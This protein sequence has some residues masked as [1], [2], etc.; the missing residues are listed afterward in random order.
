MDKE[1]YQTFLKEALE[2]IQKAHRENYLSIFAGAGVSVDSG[3]PK[4]STLMEKI[5]ESIESNADEDDFLTIEKFYEQYGEEVCYQR[6]KEWIHDNAEPNKLHDKIVNLNIKNLITTNWDNLFEKAMDN[7]GTFF[8]EIKQDNDIRYT[9]GYSR[10]V[11]MHGSLDKNNIVFRKTDYEQYSNKFPLIENYVKAIFS[12]D[13]VLLVGYSLRDSNVQQILSWLKDCSKQKKFSIYLVKTKDEFSLQ[14]FNDCREKYDVA[15]FYLEELYPQKEHSQQLI[16]FFEYIENKSVTNNQQKISP[17]LLEHE[18]DF[19]VEILRTFDNNKI[20]E[21]IEKIQ[22]N[23]EITD[24]QELQKAFLLYHSQQ[25]LESYE[26]LKRLSKESFKHRNHKIWYISEFNRKNFVFYCDNTLRENDKDTEE[27]KIEEYLKDKD[28]NEIDLEENYLKLPI[29]VR[30]NIKP[31]TTLE[32]DLYKNIIEIYHLK[33]SISYDYKVYKNGGIS[34][35]NNIDRL[36]NILSKVENQRIGFCLL[37]DYNEFFKN[38]IESIFI[39]LATAFLTR[40]K[41]IKANQRNI[42][43]QPPEM[44]IDDM[45]MPTNLLSYSIRYFKTEYLQAI[46]EKYYRSDDYFIFQNQESLKTIFTNI[47]SLFNYS[48]AFPTSYSR[49]FN[50]FLIISAWIKVGQNVFNFILENF[51]D[52]LQNNIISWNEYESM[53]YFIKCQCKKLENIDFDKIMDIVCSYMDNIRQNR[54]RGYDFSA[55]KQIFPSILRIL[56]DKK[57][58]L[59]ANKHKIL[60]EHFIQSIPLEG[61]VKIFNDFIIELYP[62]ADKALRKSISSALIEKIQQTPIEEIKAIDK[63]QKFDNPILK[64]M[65]PDLESEMLALEK[66]GLGEDSVLEFCKKCVDKGVLSPQ[67]YEVL[68][69]RLES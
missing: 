4:W 64:T 65:P 1:E 17:I 40:D 5:K 41:A 69:A 60:V 3:M 62:I 38:T 35:N 11:K 19:V 21:E 24:E 6:I 26:T 54:F 10:F 7:N 68:K 2:K 66:Q 57:C 58:P 9:T 56:N 43:N 59:T 28:A 55:A 18:L 48:G 42:E 27:K 46:L 23:T 13:I 8:H 25:Y 67:D 53:D 29:D 34:S 61:I 32:L 33:D 12:T 16:E 14:D 50:N 39:A 37:Y 44:K 47:C 52:K 45:I 22:Q 51:C 30:E 15:M 36:L 31:L 49:W 63:P 20:Q